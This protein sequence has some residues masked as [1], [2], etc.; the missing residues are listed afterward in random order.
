MPNEAIVEGEVITS[1][2]TVFANEQVS[3]AARVGAIVVSNKEQAEAANDLMKM[4]GEASKA[5]D[6]KRVELK[7]PH[8]KKGRLIDG[9]FGSLTTR[10]DTAKKELKAKIQ[11]WIDAEEKRRKEEEAERERVAAEVRRKAEAE[12]RAKEEAA[13]KA[14]AEAEARAE[15]DRKAA[16]EAEAKAKA[17]AAAGDS[18]AAAKLAGEAAKLAERAETVLQ[19]GESKAVTLQQEAAARRDVADAVTSMPAV[20]APKAAPAGFST[21]KKYDAEVV[22]L[23]ELV[24]AVAA[25]DAPITLVT[26][27]KTALRKRAEADKEAFKVPGCKLITTR[28]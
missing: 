28:V 5:L 16:E 19:S 4:I 21:R 1:E 20:A 18:K 10:L 15:A 14:K 25:G 22:N 7:E 8:L 11:A 2:I 17:A 27:D 24:K 6:A 23:M 9:F 13:A 26:I 12:A 3:V